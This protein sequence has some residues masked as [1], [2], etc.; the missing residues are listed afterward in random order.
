MADTRDNENVENETR[1][2]DSNEIQNQEKENT[3]AFSE[4]SDRMNSIEEIL[5]NMGNM[6][7]TIKKAQDSFVSMGG[8][9]R[10]TSNDSDNADDSE[11]DLL[12]LDL[13]DWN[14]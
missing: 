8:T 2:T 14:I 5:T 11:D 10:E 3:S 6:I 12:P 4:L 13:L 1:E 9:I 7:S